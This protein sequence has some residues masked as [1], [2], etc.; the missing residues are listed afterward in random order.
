M[1]ENRGEA[2]AFGDDRDAL[3][4][5]VHTDLMRYCECMTATFLDS[6]LNFVLWLFDNWTIPILP[7]LSGVFVFFCV[8]CDISWPIILDHKCNRPQ[9]LHDVESGYGGLCDTR[10]KVRRTCFLKW[11]GTG[12]GEMY[13]GGTMGS[14]MRCLRDWWGSWLYPPQSDH[15]SHQILLFEILAIQWYIGMRNDAQI[16]SSSLHI[17]SWF[18]FD[19]CNFKLCETSCIVT[20][21]N[22]RT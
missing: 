14:Q 19:V 5:N 12:H 6:H 13:C 3:T 4:D 8:L 11:Y 9:L 1:C 2:D 15:K 16:S 20:A 17:R 7:S 22:K 18:L 10:E 21:F